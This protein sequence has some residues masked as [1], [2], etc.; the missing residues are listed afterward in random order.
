MNRY[1]LEL[2]Y[3]GTNYH[4]WQVQPNA[5][6][7]QALLDDALEKALREK[8]HVIGAGRTDTGVHASYFVAH[9]EVEQSIDNPDKVVHKVNRILPQDV[10]VSSLQK[11]AGDTHSRFNAIERTYK[12]F[13]HTTK[14]PFLRHYSYR[15]YY[16]PDFDLMN[17][18]AEKLFDYIDFTSFSRLHTEVKTN[19]CKIV[20]ARWE[21]EGDQWYFI[22]SADRFLRN[23][24][25]AIVGTLFEVGRGKVSV[26]EFCQI[27]EA[28]DR[29]KAGSS[30]PG[31]ALFLTDIVYPEELFVSKV[32]KREG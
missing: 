11:V 30:A 16:I 4:G 25:R 14:N 5:S 9:F 7:V 2:A 1:F 27:I 12:Y 15:P 23:M 24:V 8:V 18:A 26:D 19:N 28:K 21:K 3:D 6:S 20:K 17:K 31:H 13:V 22:I 10:V 29:G 32:K